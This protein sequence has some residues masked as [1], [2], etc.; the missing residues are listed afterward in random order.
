MEVCVCVC[1]LE[2]GRRLQREG[3]S[4]IEGLPTQSISVCLYLDYTVS[5]QF[6]RNTSLKLMQCNIPPD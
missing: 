2:E 5:Y 1:V 3:G 6:I 4:F